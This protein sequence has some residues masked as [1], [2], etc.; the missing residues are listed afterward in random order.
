V[1]V[2]ELSLLSLLTLLFAVGC[3]NLTKPSAVSECSMQGTC[4][5]D[6]SAPLTPDAKSDVGALI[7]DGPAVVSPDG[8][9]EGRVGPDS[10][11]DG[12]SDVVAGDVADGPADV[13]I[14]QPQDKPSGAEPGREGGPEPGAEPGLEPGPE[15]P[16]IEPG[17]EPGPE[18]GTEPSPEP[19]PE[20][21]PDGGPEVAKPSCPVITGGNTGNINFGTTNAVCFVTCDT[22]QYGWGCNS[23]APTDRTLKVDGVAMTT[24][25]SQ[26]LPGRTHAN[27]Y[28]YYY[29]E[30]G[31]G[32]NTWDG[33]WWSGT[34]VAN[35]PVPPGGFT[36]K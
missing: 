6:A 5:D 35:C 29:F 20:P 17:T 27:G 21:G 33:M 12:M 14:D 7:S 36:A 2:R 19:G 10:P 1:R 34:P 24:C 31:A 8:V 9:R 16:G 25:G 11:D 23:F 13:G 18:P 22:M 26:P 32:G 28:T 15:R 30:I 3:V 4:S